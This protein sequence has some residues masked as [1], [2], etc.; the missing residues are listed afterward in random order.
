MCDGTTTDKCLSTELYQ[1]IYKPLEAAVRDYA[2][3]CQLGLLQMYTHLLRHW[4]AV[5][6]SLD[7]LPSTASSSMSSL[8]QHTNTLALTLLQTSPS[9]GT[10]SLILDFYE[11]AARLV[12]DRTLK[13]YIRIDLPPSPLIYTLLFSNS[14]ATVSRMCYILAIYKTGFETAVAT[15]PRPPQ[16]PPPPPP[17]DQQAPPPP[18]ARIDS[19]TYHR[20]Y[21]NLFNGY[22]MDMCNCFWR[23]RAFNDT[24]ANAQACTL[25]R[26]TID[27][28]AAYA[29]SVDRVLPLTSCFSLSHHPVLCLQSIERVRDLEDDAMRHDAAIRVR[30]RGPVT[31]TSLTRL[32]NAGGMRLAWAD[33][34][35][36]VLRNLADAGFPG[37]A[38]LLKNAMTVLKKSMDGRLSIQG[39]PMRM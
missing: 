29:L 31:Q 19:H 27:A 12:T 24:D 14:L 11:Q 2:P 15:R 4:T 20:A 3:S 17:D 9:V 32:A 7:A 37:I 10:D 25:S 33:Y 1:H 34:R 16:P 21:V 38:E 13:R 23:Q 6:Q 28:L 5:L 30:H 36:E 18:P 8:V 39:T 26:A 35:I 22:I